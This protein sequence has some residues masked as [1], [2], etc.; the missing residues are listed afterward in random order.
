[1][2]LAV[3]AWLRYHRWNRRDER[4]AELWVRDLVAYLRGLTWLG[5]NAAVLD[6]GCGY[7]DAGLALAG[8]VGR[9]DG[10]DT[11][12][13]AV[14]VARGRARAAGLRSRL[15]TDA[16]DLPACAYDLIF[17][18]SVFQYLDGD[19]GVTETLALFRRLLR[20]GGRGVA[21]LADLI[22][23]R[24][25][26]PLDA[27]RSLW[28]AALNGVLPA[29]LV[30]LW[31]AA[32]SPGGVRLHQIDPARTAE[33]AAAAGFD[34]ERLPRNLTPSRRRY[35]CVLTARPR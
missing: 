10:M 28:V 3:P 20:P 9:V 19:A 24:Y 14:A 17:A 35:T 29:M 16:A 18:N 1:M 34:C 2:P 13:H 12:P 11:D 23:T 25:S 33:L 32:R 22:P 7:F 30:H 6:F 4:M 8:R 5:P 26:K 15:V 21:V 27:G 31:K